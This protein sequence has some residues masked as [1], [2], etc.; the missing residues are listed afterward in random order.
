MTTKNGTQ[1]YKRVRL[2]GPAEVKPSP[3]GPLL[4]AYV[5]NISYGG[6][7]VQLKEVLKG[8]IEITIFFA[9]GS[10]G[11]IGETA[12]GHVIWCKASDSFY[13]AGIEFENLNEKNNMLTLRVIQAFTGPLQRPCP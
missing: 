1:R 13:T 10:G 5:L 11:R 7:A 2:I 12:R 3:S 8:R 4:K 6:I 9:D